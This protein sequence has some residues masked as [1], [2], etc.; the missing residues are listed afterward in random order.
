MFSLFLKRFLFFSGIPVVLLTLSASPAHGADSEA[1]TFSV[2]VDGKPA[3]TFKMAVR[4]EDNGT[5]TIAIVAKVKIKSG[6]FTYRYDHQS[7][8]VWK[9]T[10]LTSVESTTDDDGKKHAV[11]VSA[12]DDGLKVIVNGKERKG[13]ADVVTTTGWRFPGPVEKTRDVIAFDTE[14]GSETAAKI[15]SL[16]SAKLTVN[17]TAVEA[18]SFRVSGKDLDAVWWYDA[19]QRPVRQE[20][21][22]DG[23]KVVLELTE[24]T[25]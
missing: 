7:L 12:S 5:E 6:F 8:E 18:H 22:W 3:G 24:I 13:R 25:R 10:R 23:H 17:G 2:T 4:I 21:K 16:G 20:M 1:R 15:E 14:D 11:K 9:G 19:A